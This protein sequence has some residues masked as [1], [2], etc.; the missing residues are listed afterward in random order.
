MTT[1]ALGFLAGSIYST[2]VFLVFDRKNN[3]SHE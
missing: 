2:L 1:L 3:R